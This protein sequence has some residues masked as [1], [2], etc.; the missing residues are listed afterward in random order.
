MA[1]IYG[2]KSTTGDG[3][4]IINAPESGKEIVVYYRLIQSQSS[5]PTTISLKNG[6]VVLETIRCAGDAHGVVGEFL[7]IS[8][9]RCGN[10]Q[11]LY[12]NQSSAVPIHWSIAY[13]IENIAG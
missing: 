4:P 2:S 1:R 3:D 11:S 7:P 10:G 9:I 5:T 12:I 6:S 13:N 8:A